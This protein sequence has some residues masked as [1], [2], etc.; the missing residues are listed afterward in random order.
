MLL[1]QELQDVLK[2]QL[3]FIH[4]LLGQILIFTQ[5]E[6]A[7]DSEGNNAGFSNE[8]TSREYYFQKYPLMRGRFEFNDEI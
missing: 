5:L 2:F 4:I 3:S 6:H 8:P 1:Y 7:I